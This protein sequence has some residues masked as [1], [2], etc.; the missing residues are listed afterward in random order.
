VSPVT[1]SAALKDRVSA[2]SWIFHV[3]ALYCIV[4]NAL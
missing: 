4:N 3:N 2:F 1:D